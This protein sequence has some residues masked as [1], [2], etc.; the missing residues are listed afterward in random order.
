MKT[1]SSGLRVDLHG[2]GTFVPVPSK[3]ILSQIA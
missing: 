1:A 3:S 2:E